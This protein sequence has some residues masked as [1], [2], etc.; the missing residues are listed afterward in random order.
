LK[1][2]Y[3]DPYMKEFEAKV[4]D[5]IDG[6]YVILDQT[7]FYGAGGGQLSDTGEIMFEGDKSKIIDV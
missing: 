5:V 1:L 7:L 3:Q 6:K 4:V 2:Y